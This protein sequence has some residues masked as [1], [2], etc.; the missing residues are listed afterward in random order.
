MSRIRSVRVIAR[1]N[2]RPAKPG[3]S[4]RATARIH[5]FVSS[6]FDIDIFSRDKIVY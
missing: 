1:S 3:R 2:T 5:A 6:A 4:S